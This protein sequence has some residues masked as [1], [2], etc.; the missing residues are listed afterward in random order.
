MGLQDRDYVRNRGKSTSKPKVDRG[1]KDRYYWSKYDEITN[2]EIRSSASLKK[3]RNYKRTFMYFGFFSLFLFIFYYVIDSSLNKTK[4]ESIVDRFPTHSSPAVRYR[5]AAAIQQPAEPL[6]IIQKPLDSPPT[7]SRPPV[8]TPDTI[9]LHSDHAGHYRGTVLINN[10][11]MPFMIDTGAT[12]TA[13]PT[14]MAYAARLPL[15]QAY[16]TST[17]NGLAVARMTRINSL[18]IG[19]VDIRG[20]E[21]STL[22][23]LD[24]VLIGMNTLKYFRVTQDRNILTLALYPDVASKMQSIPAPTPPYKIKKTWEKTVTCD[25]DGLNCK[26]SYR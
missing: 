18:K 15:G 1:I 25:K 9:V 14:K 7:T 3:S 8:Q 23:H 20:L 13:I 2:D 21:A 19:N 16:Q 5:P 4:N 12:Q 24:E 22:D 10:V 6:D 26:T 17:A 11:S